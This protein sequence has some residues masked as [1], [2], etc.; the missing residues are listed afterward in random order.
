MFII[1]KFHSM[2]ITRFIVFLMFAALL[3]SCATNSDV[4]GLQSQIDGLKTAVAQASSDAQSAMSDLQAAQQEIEMLKKRVLAFET[5]C[6]AVSP[7]K[8]R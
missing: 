2:T 7:T 1:H 6:T 3:S 8:K 5:L 4:E